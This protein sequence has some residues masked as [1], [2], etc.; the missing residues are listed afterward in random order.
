[1]RATETSAEGKS[2]Y[3]HD[4]KGKVAESYK[5]FTKEVMKIEKLRQKHKSDLG[6]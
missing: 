3:L 6:R 4:P 2:I 5:E 1:M